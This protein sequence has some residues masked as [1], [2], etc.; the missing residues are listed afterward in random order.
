[1]D[2]S[3]AIR[4]FLLG[5]VTFAGYLSAYS[6]SKTLFTRVPVPVDAVYPM[7]V[8]SP[9]V[10]YREE[11]FLDKKRFSITHDLLVFDTNEDAANY[12]NVEAAARR[13]WELMNRLQ[14]TSFSTPAG[15]NLIQCRASYPIPGA[16]DDLI[17]VSR[18]VQL[19]FEINEI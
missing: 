18:V 6:G 5:D 19:Q 16:T 15:Y 17:K 7:A 12:R 13:G 3:P 4:T 8:I 2:L 14:R 11:D 10:T 1:M 9:V